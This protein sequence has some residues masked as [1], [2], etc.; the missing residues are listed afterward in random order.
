[1]SRNQAPRTNRTTHT[2]AVQSPRDRTAAR[3]TRGFVAFVAVAAAVVAAA[4]AGTVVATR[5][6]STRGT[7]DR[8]TG[9]PDDGPTRSDAVQ[10]AD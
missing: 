8:R 6:T 10:V 2:T 3:T 1:M 7:A 5:R 4:T 9:P